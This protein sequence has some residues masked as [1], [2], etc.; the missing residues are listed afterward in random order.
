[1]A[2]TESLELLTEVIDQLAPIGQ[3]TVGSPLRAAHWNSM[4]DAVRNMARL[5]LSREKTTDALLDERYATRDHAH[6]G[7]V[8]LT[9]FE[10]KARDLLEEAMSGGVE[11]RAAVKELKREMTALREDIDALKDQVE[12]VRIM[13]DGLRD[14]DSARQRQLSKLAVRLEGVADVEENLAGLSNR[15]ND[16][17]T[18]LDEALAFRSQLT[19]PDG[20]PIDVSA[21]QKRVDG[22]ESMRD[23][24]KTADGEIVNIREIESQL[25][26]LEENSIDRT[27]VDDVILQRLREGEILDE[28]GLVENVKSKVEDG[29]VSRFDELAKAGQDQ[30]TK[31]DE[32]NDNLA[33]HGT[34]LTAV[35][36]S[37]SSSKSALAALSG[38]PT[39]VASQDQRLKTVESRS[40][41]NET[42]V[43]GLTAIRQ[44][45]T[46][47]ESSAGRIDELNAAVKN[48][49]VRIGTVE[50]S[51]G[52]IDGVAEK[53]DVLSS[54]VKSIQGNI[55]GLDQMKAS[56]AANTG[57]LGT[58]S[59][60]VVANEAELDNL[61]GVSEQVAKLASTTEEFSQ[62]R[63][64]VDV[65]LTELAGKT[66]V[67]SS[68]VER[69]DVLE[70]TVANA[71]SRVTTLSKSVSTME[72]SM[73]TLQEFPEQVKLLDSRLAKLEKIR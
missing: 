63:T 26:R 41:A 57:A 70:K 68:V 72:S 35:E 34:R 7:K 21:I 64:G 66:V 42:A 39:Q 55:A 23:N 60:R 33:S 10:P 67:A 5:I 17:R 4:V 2:R 71:N 50:A 40:V 53:V 31:I 36:T 37:A 49:D 73:K 52:K 32:M 44:R 62:W 15:F 48:M 9:W 38:L 18:G 47:V 54:N 56:I 30:G 59:Q 45:L 6:T 13:L 69:I 29:F 61:A 58:L 3:M 25:A 51:A 28:A 16:I 19:D 27:D 65:R 1:M 43:S 20:N 8:G 12:K 11:Q 14:E 46:A 24:L 22:L